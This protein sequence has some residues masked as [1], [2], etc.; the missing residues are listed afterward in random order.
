MIKI[1]EQTTYQDSKGDLH[2]TKDGAIAS[3]LR[4]IVGSCGHRTPHVLNE[5]A[6]K[7]LV[8]EAQKIVAL[9]YQSSSF[10]TDAE[11]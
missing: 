7:K 11:G 5:A 8:A 9:L 3:E 10:P 4:I 2:E 1:V 6:A